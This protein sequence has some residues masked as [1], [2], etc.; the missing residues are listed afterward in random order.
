MYKTVRILYLL[1]IILFATFTLTV[2]S[3]QPSIRPLQ[4]T[5]DLNIGQ[6]KTVNLCDGSQVT[7]KL[8][9]I[10]ET[11][12]KLRGCIRNSDVTLEIDGQKA[13][14]QSARYHL[15]VTVGK[16][17][18]DCP[19]TKGHLKGDVYNKQVWA[20]DTDARL[21]LWPAGS[22]WI[23]PE[24][25]TCP[26]QQRWFANDTQMANEIAFVNGEER[27]D[28]PRIYYHYGLD[29][30]GVEGKVDVVAASSGIVVGVGEKVMESKTPMPLVTPSYARIH[31][32]DDR[33]WYHRYCHLDSIDPSV[34]LGQ[35]VERGQKIATLGKQGTSG[36]WAHTHFDIMAPL[37]DGRYAIVEPYAFCWQTYHDKWKTKLQAVARPHRLAAVGE[38]VKLDG[39]LSY[40]FADPASPLKY[41]WALS[42]GTTAQGPKVTT[43]YNKP[44]T[45]SEVLKV[46]DKA[47][48]SDYDFTV[49]QVLDPAKPEQ[50]PPTIHAAYFP[51]REI[52]VGDPI[53]F[54]VRS[55]RIDATDGVEHW[56]FG[57][58][59][60]IVE[61][62]SDGNAEMLAKNGYAKTTHRYEKPGDYLV[63]VSRTN[64][65]GETATAH[66]AVRVA[67]KN[68]P[69][70]GIK[71]RD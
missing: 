47:G 14:I 37:G 26:I 58:S 67:P 60:P 50:S 43:H 40:S 2:A 61:V 46:T 64:H 7:V 20:L 56:D 39:S 1:S 59:S 54:I 22:P 45:Y 32:R 70:E 17:Q 10:K 11:R 41:D 36:G 13:T 65:R 12:D 31:I 63:Q 29:F 9:D 28:Y 8:L 71:P 4:T 18:V 38:T 44:G 21:R 52:K 62:R 27:L 42:D 6:T 33:G 49:V 23:R 57:D 53:Q 24:T 25:F 51:T 34:K 16:F 68:S 35:R 69:S 30:G 15:P 19:V 66:L 3:D 5:V 48:R 55:Y